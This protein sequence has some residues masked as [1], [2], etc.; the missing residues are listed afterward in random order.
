MVV[1]PTAETRRRPN[2]KLGSGANL[3][4]LLVFSN[5]NNLCSYLESVLWNCWLCNILCTVLI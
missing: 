4:I 5:T 3:C 2:I 1:K